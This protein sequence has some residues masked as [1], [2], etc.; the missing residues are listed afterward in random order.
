MQPSR[1]TTL[2]WWIFAAMGLGVATGLALPKAI[3]PVEPFAILSFVGSLFLRALQ[4]LVVPL[5]LAAVVSSIA[6][7]GGETAFARLG[8]KTIAL[9]L[10][11]T[12]AAVLLGLVVMNTFHPGR[13]PP[14]VS[15]ALIASAGEKASTVAS[16]LEG[17]GAADIVEI[18]QR[19]IPTNI[20]EALGKNG[21]MLGIIVFSVFFGLFTAR[22][23][24]ERRERFA[25]FWDDFYEVMIRFT[26]A[27]IRFTPVGVF[28]LVATT[29]SQTGFAAFAPLAGFFGCV[30]LGLAIHLF[31]TLSVLMRVFGLPPFRHL[32]AVSP[33]L[34]TAFST[35]SSAATVPVSLECL[36][37]NAGVSRRVAG[38][39]IPLGATVNMDGTALYECAVVLFVAQIYGVDLAFG[40]QVTIVV[41]ALLTSIGVAGIPAASLVAI[42]VILGAVGL[43]LEAIGVILA[44][45]RIL[46]MSRTA[47]NVYGDTVVASIVA[48][49]E[50][51]TLYAEQR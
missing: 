21:E 8:V 35:A 22:L 27:V 32:R 44:V 10:A 2:H 43:P 34:L 37:R 6:K 30:I 40:T 29:V 41:L 20:F 26:D 25:N 46:D 31:V 11:T 49:T 18:F 38:F 39:T 5:I 17:R 19:M 51:E 42:V 16:H 45:D 23:P 7:L 47:V 14:E 13:V 33:A 4:M 28:A 15:Q 9:Y 3:G 48:K 24:E 50:G 12:L 1:G 36:Q